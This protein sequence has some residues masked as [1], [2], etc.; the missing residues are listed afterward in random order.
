MNN[1][2]T[3]FNQTLSF[4]REYGLP[5]NKKR[6][7]LRELLQVKILDFIY[8]QK[9]STGLSFVGGTS[10]RL[11]KNLDRFS[12]DLDFDDLNL[13]H[14]QIEKIVTKIHQSL[15]KEEIKTDLYQ[16]IKEKKHYYEFRFPD[17]LHQLNISIN[18]KEK[19]MIKL[20]YSD[21]WKGQ[22]TEVATLSRYGFVGNT[23]TNDINQLLIQKLTAY[24]NRKQTQPRDLYDIVWLFS[25]GAKIDMG[26]IKKNRL[27]EDL[28]SRALIK[29]N[30]EKPKMAVYKRRLRPFLI[31]EGNEN[32]I[33]LLPRILK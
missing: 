17:L 25:H 1:I 32:K 8:R 4:A 9:E 26:F 14:N 30:Q 22:K 12:E 28:A 21:F 13:N 2:V 29:F 31:N 3:N 20:D 10:L 7:I 27:P 11:L 15:Q 23:I 18:P 6:A 16:N 19:L 5:I 24:L 33:E